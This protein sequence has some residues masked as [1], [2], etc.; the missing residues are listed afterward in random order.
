MTRRLVRKLYRLLPFKQ[1]LFELLRHAGIPETVYRHLHFRG[2]F[3]VPVDGTSFLIRHHGS[4]IEN[5][6]FWSGIHGRWEGAALRVWSRA[7]QEAGTICDVGANSGLYTLAAAALNPRARVVAVEP[8]PRVYARL[9]ENV[10]LNGYP[11]LLLKAAAS[12]RDGGGE[13][14]DY[15]AE[16]VL[17]ASLE[18]PEASLGFRPTSVSLVRLDTLVAQG[19]LPPP[20]L[21]KID[22]EGHEAAVLRGLGDHLAARRPTLIVEVLSDHAAT[23]VAEAVRGLGYR[24]FDLA[25]EG[26]PRE[27][28]TVRRASN[29]NLLLCRPDQV[30]PLLG[31]WP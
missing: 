28:D 7:V 20:D 25:A 13:L 29:L 11:C 23:A 4:Q 30:S 17:A 9:A 2:V 27:L 14:W 12:D 3:R 16:H 15:P 8:V 22:V 10:A 6:V 31:A 21:L 24:V 5:E 18:R 19:L 26:E 1:P